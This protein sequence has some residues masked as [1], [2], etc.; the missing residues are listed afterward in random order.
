VPRSSSGWLTYHANG[1]RTGEDLT[2]PPLRAVH[3]TWTSPPL[4]GDVYAEPLVFGSHVFVA[5]ENDSVYA[6]R[7][8]TGEVIWRA[9]LGAP[10][11]QSALPCGNIDPTGITG[12]PAIDARTGTLYA[13]AFVLPGRHDLVAIDTST[14]QVRF[15]RSID[16]EGADPLVHQQ[17]GA[18]L[19][20]NGRVYT[21]F[22]G[23]FGDCGD[24][25]GMVVGRSLD[26]SGPMLVY[27]VPSGARAG[28]WAPSGA[29]EDSAGNLLVATGNSGSTTTFDYGSAVIR[30][31]P[32]LRVI[33]WFAP[34]NWAALNS[35]DVD[36]GSIGPAVLSNG[37]VFQSGKEGVG[38]LL[39]LDHLGGIGGE[40]FEGDVCS[41][42]AF[43]G[44]ATDS[45][46][47]YVPCTDGLVALRI[48]PG[49]SFEIAWRT[50]GFDAGPPI[51]A[52][53]A[54]WS[55]DLG[56]G[57]LLGFERGTGRPLFSASIG[58]VAHFVTP[59]AASGRI[60]VAAS[61]RVVAFG[62]I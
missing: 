62:G 9:H 54:V 37:L 33:G 6:L 21:P 44:T 24:F 59:T 2:S 36:L 52:G 29:T 1:A 12:T 28:I 34:R 32:R 56:S 22:G 38:Y 47:V 61:Q 41:G 55:V 26:G 31:S 50:S 18:L 60:Y 23:L 58:Q 5:T 46:F 17:R 49:P 15:R 3:R 45:S 11:P 39:R 8:G 16:P 51:L 43:G 35:G 27:R 19:V 40:A 25:H 57:R 42:G 4:D 7:V 13:V 14:G 53:G 30:L 20:A 10:V 48:T